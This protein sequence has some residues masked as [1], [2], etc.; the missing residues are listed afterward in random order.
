MVEDAGP[1]DRPVHSPA[2]ATVSLPGWT[3]AGSSVSSGRRACPARCRR[4]PP[5]SGCPCR[6]P[7]CRG[8]RTARRTPGAARVSMEPGFHLHLL[9]EAEGPVE[10]GA[11]VVDELGVGRLL[12]DG[13]DQ[14]GDL[15]EV[16]HR[17]LDPQEVSAVLQ[18]GHAVQHHPRLRGALPGQERRNRLLLYSTIQYTLPVPGTPSYTGSSP[19]LVESVGQPDRLDHPAVLLDQHGALGKSSALIHLQTNVAWC[20][21][22]KSGASPPPS[23]GSHCTGR[24]GRRQP[25]RFK[26]E[27]IEAKIQIRSKFYPP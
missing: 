25:G 18:G 5:P 17:G 22:I 14:G 23:A 16:G 3:L 6:R 21:V 2:I 8:G 11:V 10:G 13:A 24:P 15:L 4:T 1:L 19:E 12:P 27:Q 9:P 20:N 7:T 26:S